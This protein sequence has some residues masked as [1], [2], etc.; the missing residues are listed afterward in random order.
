MRQSKH[1]ILHYYTKDN[2]GRFKCNLCFKE[3]TKKFLD[4][5]KHIIFISIQKFGLKLKKEERLSCD[6][7]KESKQP[8]NK[9]SKKERPLK[10]VH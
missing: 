8:R 9:Y 4:L 3:Y 7:C 5:L 2:K 10:N 6:I 1:Q